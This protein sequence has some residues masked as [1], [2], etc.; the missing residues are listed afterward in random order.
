MKNWQFILIIFCL[1]IF[2]VPKDNFY[3]QA[4]QKNCCKTKSISNDCC[5]DKHE[6]S[7]QNSKK[8]YCNDDCCSFCMTCHSFIEN[9]SSRTIMTELSAFQINKKLHYSYADPYF[10]NGLKDI[11]QPPKLG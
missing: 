8:D 1:G 7:N 4:S 6:T 11:W 9:F 10:S 3:A 2:L 5:T